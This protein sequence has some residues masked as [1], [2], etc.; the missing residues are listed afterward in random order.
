MFNFAPDAYCQ[1]FALLEDRTESQ[2][3]NWNAKE[4]TSTTIIY[5]QVTKVDM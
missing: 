4:N 2:Q 5:I 3:T 1:W